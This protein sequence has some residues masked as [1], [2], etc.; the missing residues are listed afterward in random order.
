MALALAVVA[1]PYLTGVGLAGNTCWRKVARPACG[2]RYHERQGR[3]IGGWQR[4]EI[5]TNE[6]AVLYSAARPY[7][8]PR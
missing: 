7:F 5:C 3:G 8:V 4:G 6:R 2:P 1:G